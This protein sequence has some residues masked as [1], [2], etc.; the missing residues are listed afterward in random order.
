MNITK[1][2]GI[3]PYIAKLKALG[4]SNTKALLLKGGTQNGRRILAEKTGL[5]EKKLLELV[6]RADLMRIR[7]IGTEYSDL[8]FTVGVDTLLTLSHR[9]ADYLL[10]MMSNKNMEKSLVQQLPSLNRITRWIEEAKNL[11]PMVSF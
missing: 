7:G 2:E 11:P 1:I 4:I 6:N 3:D 10:T 9:K 8:L 5:P